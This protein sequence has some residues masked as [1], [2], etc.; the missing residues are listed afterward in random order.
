MYLIP[1]KDTNKD[2][3]AKHFNHGVVPLVEENPTFYLISEDG[4]HNR[5]VNA[6][7]YLNYVRDTDGTDPKSI[8]IEHV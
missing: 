6:E 7:T 1:I 2:F 5:I 3:I 8:V 4:N